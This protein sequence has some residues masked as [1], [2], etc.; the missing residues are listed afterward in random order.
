[1][2]NKKFEFYLMSNGKL[3][4]EFSLG[5]VMVLSISECRVGEGEGQVSRVLDQA[6]AGVPGAGMEVGKARPA[7]TLNSLP[8]YREL[9]C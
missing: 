7:E 5:S 1:M 3:W 6:E 4:K 9:G 8:F 2:S